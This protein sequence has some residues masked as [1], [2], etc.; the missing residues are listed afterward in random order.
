VGTTGSLPGV[1]RPG[2]EA[3]HSPSSNDKVK[4]AWN[5]TYTTSIRLHGVLLSYEIA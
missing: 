1:K 5:Y 4:N 3:D 2:R